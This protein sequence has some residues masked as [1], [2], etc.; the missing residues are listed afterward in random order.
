MITEKIVYLIKSPMVTDSRL[1]HTKTMQVF[2]KYCL[3]SYNYLTT[4]TFIFPHAITG[5]CGTGNWI[6]PTA[7]IDLD[8]VVIG[9]CCTIGKNVV[10]EKNTAIGNNVTI[11]DGAVIGSEGFEFRNLAGELVPVLH[12][13]GVIIHDNVWIGQ[14]VCI[15]KSSFGNWT[16][17]GRDS[18]IH[19]YTH[20]GH[21]IKIGQYTT[22][23]EGIMVG[24]YADIGNRVRIG[25]KSSL[26]DAI[27]LD[28]DVIVP[29]CTVVTRDIKKPGHEAMNGN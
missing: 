9:N 28:D 3:K 29:D 27:T 16:E 12:T 11:E 1:A 14:S 4:K 5:S 20:L 22:L 13:G 10:I 26:A 24:G 2:L 23:A 25:R 6:H 8:H 21:G 15:D 17:I 7:V 18:Q 19:A